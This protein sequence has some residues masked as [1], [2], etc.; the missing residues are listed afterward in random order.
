MGSL[1][2]IEA[3]QALADLPGKVELNVHAWIKA[4][5]LAGD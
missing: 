3:A 4:V 5:Q 2:R 1:G